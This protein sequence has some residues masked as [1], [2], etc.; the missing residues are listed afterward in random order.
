MNNRA[1]YKKQ[2]ANDNKERVNAASNRYYYRNRIARRKDGRKRDKLKYQQRRQWIDDYRETLSCGVCGYTFE[3]RPE[4]CEF[5]HRNAKTK[6][7]S[8][9]QMA[10][11]SI[12]SIVNEINKCDVLCANCHRMLHKGKKLIYDKNRAFI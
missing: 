7:F 8:I 3:N 6:S 1:T 5:H 12:E 4:C 2:W 11:R 10:N 9:S